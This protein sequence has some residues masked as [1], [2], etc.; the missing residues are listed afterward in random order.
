VFSHL[1]FSIGM[2]IT[3]LPVGIPIAHLILLRRRHH[4]HHNLPDLPHTQVIF[5]YEA[6]LQTSEDVMVVIKRATK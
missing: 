2:N 5:L 3:K 1:A 6:L 4:H